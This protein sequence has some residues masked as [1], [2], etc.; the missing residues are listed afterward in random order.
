MPFSKI[1]IC[2]SYDYFLLDY[3]ICTLPSIHYYFLETLAN[4]LSYVSIIM[5]LH[6][7][8]LSL[9]F[10]IPL[11]QP[12][13]LTHPPGTST[14]LFPQSIPFHWHPSGFLLTF[15]GN[16][17]LHLYPPCLLIHISWPSKKKL[18]LTSILVQ[19]ISILTLKYNKLNG[20]TNAS[21]ILNKLQHSTIHTSSLWSE[22]TR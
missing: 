11:W 4:K 16:S 10:H 17:I 6:F 22:G 5:F 19:S 18:I 12:R 15:Y 20:H 2:Y 3:F 7:H 9:Q 1:I 8:N 21:W 14:S 13:L